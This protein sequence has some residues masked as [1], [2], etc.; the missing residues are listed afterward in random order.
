MDYR[1]KNMSQTSSPYTEYLIRAEPNFFD[2]E[3][4]KPGE[5]LIN[6]GPQHP[7]MHGVLRVETITAPL[8]REARRNQ[9]L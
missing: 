9:G 4:L 5:M 8:L 2:P 1:P 3:K 6:M 7:S